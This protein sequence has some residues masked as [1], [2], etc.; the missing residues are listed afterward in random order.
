M[1]ED[2]LLPPFVN[3]TFEEV[4]HDY[5]LNRDNIIYTSFNPLTL[6]PVPCCVERIVFVPG[7][8]TFASEESW[9]EKRNF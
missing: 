8:V 7:S 6:M 9:C 2:T 3:H 4:G 5:V 1:N